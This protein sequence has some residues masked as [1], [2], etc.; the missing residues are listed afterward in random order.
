MKTHSTH[1]PNSGSALI[2]VLFSVT[3]LSAVSG[4]V[5]FNVKSRRGV[6]HQST[7]WQE[8][9]AAAEAGVQQAIAQLDQGLA[10]ERLPTNKVRYVLDL[11][12][13]GISSNTAQADYFLEPLPVTRNG[14]IRTYYKVVSNGTVRL[15]GPKGIGADVRDVNLRKLD[16]ASN[17]QAGATRK[18][19]AMVR[20]VYNTD[21]ALK[22]NGSIRMN[23]H[24]ISVD[25]FDTSPGS[26]RHNNNGPA[27]TMG[28]YNLAHSSPDWDASYLAN[29]STNSAAISPGEATIYG[30]VLS[31]GGVIGSPNNIYGEIRDDYNEP[32]ASQKPPTWYVNPDS[33]TG[34][35]VGATNLGQV[36]NTTPIVGGANGVPVKYTVSS[37]A[38]S[39]GKTVTF[40]NPTNP[41]G[42]TSSEI[43]IYVTGDLSTKGG[44]NGDGS[45][46]VN[47]GV[48][49]KIYIAGSV[50]LGG[51]GINNLGG[52]AENLAFY[53]VNADIDGN[54]STT[55]P[56]WSFG[57]SSQ[58]VGTV[59]A[60]G[61]NV[62]LNGGGNNG[63]YIGNIVAHTAELKGN[64]EIRYD[65][66]LSK[67]G[68]IMRFELMS[69]FEDTKKDGSF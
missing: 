58:F 61:A 47:P 67:G 50:A 31:D 57:G 21:G 29:V 45:F 19:H 25:S 40:S 30:D 59:Y 49:V 9:L 48:K 2:V 41:T 14:A 60:P 17:V 33:K 20:P 63:T 13:A 56:T 68:R 1:L 7:A 5:L 66:A 43:E 12:H 24:N 42:V 53:G 16:V 69:W 52:L 6:V 22:T 35:V 8:S 39:G 36:R 64:V 26:I 11:P 15:N 4:A 62:I 55:N 51:N 23:T 46:V 65:E 27:T 32:I 37:F 54:V 18:I 3:L 38:L 28:Y 44:G 34:A 10:N